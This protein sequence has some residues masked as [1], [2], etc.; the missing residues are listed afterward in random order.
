MILVGAGQKVRSHA[1]STV[2]LAGWSRRD[3][4]FFGS[5]SWAFDQFLVAMFV[6]VHDLAH[7]PP[8]LCVSRLCALWL[9]IPASPHCAA[10]RRPAIAF[11][12]ARP[13]RISSAVLRPSARLQAVGAK[14]LDKRHHL[15][16][17]TR[18][19]H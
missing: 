2:H 15:W 1:V 4:G 18:L 9:I 14:A 11:P 7:H 17:R 5:S 10:F 16:P 19:H 13:S 8:P 6:D 3:M 12:A